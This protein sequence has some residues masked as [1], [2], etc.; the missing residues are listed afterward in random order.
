VTFSH[1]V[2][3]PSSSARHHQSII[4]GFSFSSSFPS[5]EGKRMRATKI[6]HEPAI[7]PTPPS[8]SPTYPPTPQSRGNALHLIRLRLPPPRSR[9][10]NIPKQR[11]GV[12]VIQKEKLE[13]LWDVNVYHPRMRNLHMGLWGIEDHDDDDGVW[14]LLLGGNFGFSWDTTTTQTYIYNL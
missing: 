13:I 4:C 8:S 12:G 3:I 1:I 7:D 10:T 11:E 9:E 2:K 5:F 14:V 6:P